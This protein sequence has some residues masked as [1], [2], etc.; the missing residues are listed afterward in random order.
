MDKVP[1]L[2]LREPP[3]PPWRV[4]TTAWIAGTAVGLI[5]LITLYGLAVLRPNLFIA[6]PLLGDATTQLVSLYG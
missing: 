6:S 1:T 4:G 3:R 2:T 5:G